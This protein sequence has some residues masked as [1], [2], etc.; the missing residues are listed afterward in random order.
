MAGVN[1][2]PV[3][4]ASPSDMKWLSPRAFRLWHNV[5]LGGMLPSGLEDDA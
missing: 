4:L 3:T 2:D 1:L 5:G